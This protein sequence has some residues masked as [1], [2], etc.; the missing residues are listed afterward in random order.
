MTLNLGTVRP[1]STILVPFHAF[2]S[3]DPS[4]SVIIS[5]FTLADIGIYKALSM[6]ERV[7]TSGIVLLETD[8][9]NIDGAIGIHG[10]SVDLS[11]NGTVEFYASGS[12]Y[13][14]TVGPIT[15]DGG[16]VEFIPALFN[17]GFPE[18][19]INTTVASAVSD[20]QFIL[21]DGPAEAD[22]LIGCPILIQALAASVGV[23]IQIG[24]VVDYI[25]TTKEVFLAVDPGGGTIAQGDHVAIMMPVTGALDAARSRHDRVGTIGEPFSL[26]LSGTCASSLTDTTFVSDL[27]IEENDQYKGRTI[28]FRND[29]ATTALQGQATE[30]LA[31]TASSNLFT[32][33][34]LTRAP[35][36]TDTFQ[37]I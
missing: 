27:P 13:Y 32:F 25:V 7:S 33:K 21:N 11:D 22:V 23:G 31:T 26:Q 29:T 28:M 18:A 9:I 37:I 6:T 34:A 30:I 16:T 5:G 2:D 14:I 17:I 8:G 35:G 1:G 4:N 19:I 12:H 24:Y 10:F 20:T 36:A 15:I 3:N